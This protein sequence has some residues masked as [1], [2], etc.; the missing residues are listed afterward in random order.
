MD[1]RTTRVIGV[2]LAFCMLA[3]ALSIGILAT[4]NS[5]SALDDDNDTSVYADPDVLDYRTNEE[6]VYADPGAQG[7]RINS[8]AVTADPYILPWRIIGPD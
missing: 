1:K 2:G 8:P 6:S 5:A 7:F 4:M 3:C